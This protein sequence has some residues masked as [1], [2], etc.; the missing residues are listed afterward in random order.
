MSN[1]YKKSTFLKWD[2]FI[3]NVFERS[4]TLK[5]YRYKTFWKTKVPK[6][7]ERKKLYLAKKLNFLKVF[8][9]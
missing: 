1:I 5:Q 8:V 4:Q 6:F 3:K 7:F 2:T 9:H